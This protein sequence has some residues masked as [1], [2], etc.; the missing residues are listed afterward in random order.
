MRRVLPASLAALV[1]LALALCV[2]G[3]RVVKMDLPREIDFTGAAVTVWDASEPTV[4]VA[5]EYTATV[6][7]T[8]NEFSAKYGVKVDLRFAGRQE[9]TDL[10]AGQKT[11]DVPSLVFTGEWPVASPQ[12]TD[13]SLELPLA[14]YLDAATAY[15]Q[16]DGRLLGIPAYVQWIG[17]ATQAGGSK[18]TYLV[19][20][21]GFFR[22]ALDLPSSWDADKVLSYLSWVNQ[23]WGAPESNPLKAWGD[24]IAASLYPA[25]PQ[26]YRYLR[27]LG[28]SQVSI[29]PL[30]GPE[31]EAAFYYTVPAYVV[32]AKDGPERACAIRLGVALA[33]NL[34]RWAARAMGGVPALVA[35]VP[36]FN[37]ESGL[38]YEERSSILSTVAKR[39]LTA[40]AAEESMYAD[41][42]EKALRQA[43]MGYLSGKVSEA[44]SARSIQETLQRHTKP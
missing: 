5:P 28:K 16:K 40:A 27:P 11:G 10:L 19:E 32:L 31:G 24:G 30:D 21:P 23:R 2:T 4:S 26:L 42:I 12:A 3:C 22:A 34:G 20:S 7:S 18:P 37:L 8:V 38:S 17:V 6:R 1:A 33:A 14:N 9:I 25:T 43:A 44:D 15:W 36:V 41:P 29:A 35:D 13:I 39:R